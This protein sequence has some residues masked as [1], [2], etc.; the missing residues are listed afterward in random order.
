M[1]R[2][3][4]WKERASAPTGVDPPGVHKGEDQARA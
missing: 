4:V 2:A 1:Q 3:T